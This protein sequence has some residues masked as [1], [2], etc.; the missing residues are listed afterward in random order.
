MTDEPGDAKRRWS[1]GQGKWTMID[2][3]RSSEIRSEAD[4]CFDH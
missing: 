2:P 1:M 3:G 4:F